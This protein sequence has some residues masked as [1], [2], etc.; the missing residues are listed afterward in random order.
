MHEQAD[1]T[2]LETG[3]MVNPDTGRDTPYEELWLDTELDEAKSKD[4]CF[5]VKHEQGAH[6]G[7]IV[8]LGDFCQG[9]ARR[10]GEV[11]AERWEKNDG[12]WQRTVRIGSGSLVCDELLNGVIKA[13]NGAS[14]TS[15]GETWAVVEA[16]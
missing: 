7:M 8:K 14:F 9:V 10:G 12:R 16:Y 2:T 13:E 4:A 1:G 6:R 15:G 3:S 11:V 5:V